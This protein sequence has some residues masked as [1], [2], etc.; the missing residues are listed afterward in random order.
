MRILMF[1]WE[2]PPHVVGGLGKHVGELLPSLSDLPGMELHLVTPR[3]AGG[4]PLE[5]LGPATIHRVP[6]P[7]TSG[8]VYT[9]AWQ[10]NLRLQ[11]YAH[12]LWQES[13]PFDLIHVHDW[14]V[15]FV[16]VAFKHS[17]KVPLLSTIHATEQGRWRGHLPGELS[18]AIA[19]AE[20]WLIYESWRIVACSQYMAGEI[21]GYFHCPRDKID[22]IPNGVNPER[23]ERLAGEELEHF[24]AMHALPCEQIVFSVGRLVYEKGLQVLVR[25][26]PQ[27]LWQ[28]PTVKAV[29]AGQG[30]E[31]DWLRSMAWNL[32][33]GDKVLFTGFVSDEE[34][35]W[36]FKIAD[37]AAFPSLYEPFGIVALE[38]M[39]ARCPVVVSELGGLCDVV[40]HNDT[41]V[42]VYPDDPNSLA[43]GILYTLQH[44]ELAA[45]RVER[46]YRMVRD[47]YNWRYIAELTAGVYQQIVAERA[48]TDW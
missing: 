10:T 15:A 23:F 4:L 45:E 32:G 37:V 29:I 2:Y 9:T 17:Y 18:R 36:L 21:A 11:E 19:H 24:R 28:Q 38:A 46:A 12:R 13:G 26:L 30:P 44:P 34:R 16:G 8:D 20:W 40:R 14:L 1:S 43:W 22:V 47:E 48:A 7:V 31:L 39:A 5:R 6:P 35:D 3:W 27:V 33:V 42:T 41:G 25:A